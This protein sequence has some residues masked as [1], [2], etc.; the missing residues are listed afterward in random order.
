MLTKI[1]HLISHSELPLEH[2]RAER[3]HI[4]APKVSLN[5]SSSTHYVRRT[6]LHNAYK[7]KETL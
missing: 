1:A 5:L 3:T 6:Y 7:M 4:A 2:S